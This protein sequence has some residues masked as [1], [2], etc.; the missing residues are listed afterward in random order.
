MKM[1]M[2]MDKLEVIRNILQIHVGKSNAVKS[3]EIAKIIGIEENATHAQ[4]RNLIFECAIKYNLPLAASRKG[5]YLIKN[6][7]EYNEYIK[8]LDSR[9]SGIEERKRIITVNYSTNNS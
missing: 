6:N 7:D 4:T 5:Y 1:K 2:N 9:I 8:N 3:W